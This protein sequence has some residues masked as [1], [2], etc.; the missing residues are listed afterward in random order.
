MDKIAQSEACLGTKIRTFWKPWYL[1]SWERRQVEETHSEQQGMRGGDRVKTWERT[2]LLNANEKVS[3]RRV[4]WFG[5][6]RCWWPKKQVPD[7]RRPECKR[8]RI[9][10]MWRDLRWRQATPGRS[11]NE[12]GERPIWNVGSEEVLLAVWVCNLS[13]GYVWGGGLYSLSLSPS[14]Q[15]IGNIVETL[16]YKGESGT[17]LSSRTP[18]GGKTKW[19]SLIHVQLFVT[20]WTIQSLEFSRPEYWSGQ[21]IPSPGDLPYLGIKLGSPALK[22]DSLPTELQGKPRIL[23]WIA[24]PFS[25]GSSLPKNQTGVSCI[26]G[27]FFTIW[28]T[29]EVPVWTF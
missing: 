28:A 10:E 8:L 27:R 3:P 9:Q 19:K 23:E 16:R 5:I 26:A 29:R 7:V 24:Y 1:E 17:K 4:V 6:R 15:Q 25:R 2:G 22:A 14:V 12:A 18:R 21:P 20:P 11:L 13:W